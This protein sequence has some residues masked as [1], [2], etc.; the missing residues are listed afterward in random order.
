MI[1]QNRN[2]IFFTKFPMAQFLIQKFSRGVERDNGGKIKSHFSLL[3]K[4]V[5]PENIS[6]FVVLVNVHIL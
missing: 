3:N 2:H 6:Y 4:N 5:F 1:F